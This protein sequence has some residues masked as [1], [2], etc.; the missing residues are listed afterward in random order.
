MNSPPRE[1]LLVGNPNVGKSVFFGFLTGRYVTVSNYPGTTIEVA[2]GMAEVGGQRFQVVD[3][4]GTNQLTPS[5]E[6]ERVTRDFVLDSSDALVLQ[7]ADAKN[8]RRALLLSL[9]LSE[10]AVPFTLALNMGDEARTRGIEVDTGG[11]A[12]MLGIPVIETTAIAGRGMEL[13]DAAITEARPSHWRVRYSAP[14]EAAIERLLPY[15]PTVGGRARSVA[16][17]LLAASQPLRETLAQHLGLGNRVAIWNEIEQIQSASGGP[18]GLTIQRTRLAAVEELASLVFRRI[19]PRRRS[20]A[21][22]LS[23][24]ALHPVKGILVLGTLLYIMLWFV[25]L[26]GAG[27]LVDL[28][29]NG[30]FGQVLN[31]LAIR[32]TDALLP[33]PHTHLTQ[34]V[35]IDLALP[36]TPSTSIPLGLGWERT[37]PVSA[38]ETT[39]SASLNTMQNVGVF[40]HDLLVGQYGVITM[41]MAYGIAIVLPIVFTF[42]L[43]FS[44][45]EDSGYLPRLAVMLN[46]IFKS[47]GLNGKA[48]LP[49]VLGL[50]CDTMATMTARILETRKQRLI[51]TLLLALGVPCSAQLGVLLAMMA[52]ISAVGTVVWGTIVAGSMLAVGFLAARVLPGDRGDFL[53]EIPP[54]RKPVLSNIIIKTAARIDWYLREVVPLFIL[55]TVLL[56]VLDRS[57]VL[58]GIR[59]FGAPLVVHWLGLPA[60]TTD[61]FLVGFLRRD[62]GAV[63]LLQ[64]GTGAHALL[65]SAQ[66]LVCMVV[67]TLFVPCVAN[68]FIIVREHGWKMALAMS[69]FIFPFAFFMGGVVRFAVRVLHL[70]V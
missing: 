56:F 63:L 38:F 27:T 53:L 70:P 50:G 52:R 22:R 8:L 6:D 59:R 20:F 65:D 40:L 30:L 26:F 1:L 48:V 23:S 66:V 47:I 69:A 45:M 51:V 17:Q 60:D 49:M 37:V 33:F 28:M 36:L 25:G 42:F 32:A 55:G 61:A 64:A 9:E 29:E 10:L 62:Y 68:V 13:L 34:T 41:A 12:E 7:V 19:G 15:L 3:T 11:L 58:Q 54:I 67:I 46:N 35:R 14:V 57:H 39:A 24:W 4:P 16:L 18:L 2:R 21:E 31:P 5:S 43:L 44:V